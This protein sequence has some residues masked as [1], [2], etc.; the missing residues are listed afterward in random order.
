MIEN[1]FLVL[2]ESLRRRRSVLTKRSLAK[3]LSNTTTR[4]KID[5]ET[6]YKSLEYEKNRRN[7]NEAKGKTFFSR[8]SQSG[9]ENRKLAED[10]HKIQLSARIKTCFPRNAITNSVCGRDGFTHL[11]QSKGAAANINNK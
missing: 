8:S 3:S 2:G 7:P 5:K 11:D 4:K 9:E 6:I 1:D 10:K